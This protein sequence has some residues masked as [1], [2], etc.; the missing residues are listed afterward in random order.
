MRAVCGRRHQLSSK[1]TQ[2]KS[3]RRISHPVKLLQDVMPQYRIVKPWTLLPPS[4]DIAKAGLHFTSKSESID[5]VGSKNHT[6]EQG[7]AGVDELEMVL[8]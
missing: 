8:D 4:H 6:K 7:H 1:Y 3:V 2:R 5:F